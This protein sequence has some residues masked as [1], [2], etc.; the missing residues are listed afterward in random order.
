MHNSTQAVFDYDITV[1]S[2]RLVGEQYAG[3]G[4]TMMKALAVRGS[5]MVYETD[6]DYTGTTRKQARGS[7]LP[8][9]DAVEAV[10][11][12]TKY[13]GELIGQHTSRPVY[14]LPNAI[15]RD[16]FA[17]LATGVKR[18]DTVRV[19]LA[20]TKSHYGDWE[21]FAEGLRTINTL[22][23]VGGTAFLR[24]TPTRSW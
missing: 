4:P 10:T 11:V 22:A 20:G 18:D 19:M 6:D 3:Y 23:G 21:I 14:V 17:E 12:S 13:L 7:C 15:A 9:L 1:I 16:W 24:A 2:R 5:R 8:F